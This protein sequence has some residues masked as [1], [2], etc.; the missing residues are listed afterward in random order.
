[1]NATSTWPCNKNQWHGAHADQTKTGQATRQ[2]TDRLI[3]KMIN[4]CNWQGTQRKQTSRCY[5]AWTVVFTWQYRPWSDSINPNLQHF[6]F[7][8]FVR[9][10]E[11]LYFSQFHEL[12]MIMGHCNCYK[13]LLKMLWRVILRRTASLVLNPFTAGHYAFIFWLYW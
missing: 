3:T 1:M 13:N 9:S 12:A 11:I 2:S 7:W 4:N 10:L 6:Q 8:R 5:G